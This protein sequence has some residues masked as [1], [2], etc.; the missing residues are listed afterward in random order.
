MA[1]VKSA[2]IKKYGEVEG[3]KRWN[4]LNFGKGTIDWYI[5]KFGEI[6]GKSKYLDKNKKLSVS[7]STLRASGKTDEEIFQIRSRHANKS[8]QTLQNMIS[9]Y[10][11]RVGTEKYKIYREKNKLSSVR[12]LEY[13]INKCGDIELAKQELKKVQRR[14]KNWF[15]SI[16][17]EVDGIE[18]YYSTN[19]KRGRTL[20]NYINKYGNDVGLQKY[21]DACKKWKDGQR[22]IFNSTGQLEVENY[23]VEC[24]FNVKGSRCETGIILSELEKTAV[25]KNNTLYPDIIVNNKYIIEYNGD[26]WHANKN[27][28]PNDDTIVGRINK[29][30]GDIRERDNEKYNIYKNRGYITIVIW[31][32]E[33]HA[34]KEIIKSKLKQILL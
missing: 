31:D 19:S 29:S 3:L 30:A 15:I 1:S 32:S 26:Y 24:G 12:R 21:I 13:W 9:R 18:K 10:G 4:Q 27:I 34:Q 5:T 8:K 22:G 17:G 2:W 23:L 6:D 28:F 20:Q 33:W 25:I 11:Q 16:Y 7:I 14:D